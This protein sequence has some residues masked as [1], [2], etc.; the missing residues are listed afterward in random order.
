MRHQ[1]ALCVPLRTAQRAVA[2]Y[3]D[4]ALR[5]HLRKLFYDPKEAIYAL[6]GQRYRW[7]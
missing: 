2:L 4:A 6:T 1:F 5:Q 3:E 7:A